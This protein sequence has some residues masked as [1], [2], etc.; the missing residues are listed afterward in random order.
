M[1]VKTAVQAADHRVGVAHAHRKRGNDGMVALDNGFGRFGGHAL[2]P[3]ELIVFFRVTLVMRIVYRID[4]TDILPDADVQ[5]KFLDAARN[6][7]VAPDQQ[8]AGDAF[9][10]RHLRR[11]Q[12]ARIFSFGVYHALG[13]GRGRLGCM[14]HRTHEQARMRHQRA[15]PFPVCLHIRNGSRSH[16]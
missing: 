11:A 15:Q 4:N 1:L 8:G 3:H 10:E 14:E 13:Q 6:D 2:A 12:Y 16:A 7:V 9:I 5:A